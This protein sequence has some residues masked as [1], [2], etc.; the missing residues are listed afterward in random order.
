MSTIANVMAF[1]MWWIILVV[2]TL[3][4]SSSPL[5]KGIA[6]FFG[7]IAGFIAV[8][9]LDAHL[10]KRKSLGPYS[11]YIRVV[12]YVPD[13]FCGERY[14]IGALLVDGDDVEFVSDGTIGERIRLMRRQR[15]VINHVCERM[16]MVSD[17]ND[18][19]LGPGVI[20]IQFEVDKPRPWFCE[21]D[22]DWI[23][24]HLFPRYRDEGEG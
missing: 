3:F 23:R 15:L 12:Y 20:G 1:I 10:R 9:R 22:A 17:P 16:A 8:D 4:V 19:T 21:I 18:R 2:V 6:I 11:R 5:T 24:Q 14:A 7:M 13:P